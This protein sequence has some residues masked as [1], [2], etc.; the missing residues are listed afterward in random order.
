MNCES[1]QRNIDSFLLEKKRPLTQNESNH[2]A[3]CPSCREYYDSTFLLLKLANTLKENE[4]TQKNASSLTESIMLEINK[5]TESKP[6]KKQN[7]IFTSLNF[8]RLLAAASICLLMIFGIEQYRV[9]DK[10]EKSETANSSISNYP[11]NLTGTFEGLILLKLKF[12]NKNFEKI[13][14]ETGPGLQNNKEFLAA[15]SNFKN[16]NFSKK[17]LN[18]F[19]G[20]NFSEANANNLIEI[21][22]SKNSNNFI[23]N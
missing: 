23:K 18:D 9:L 1:V 15:T 17:E 11:Q 8:Q 19:L 7:T 14:K 5:E 4:P 21:I 6:V 12:Q 22:A 16:G 10:I 2:I 20:T 13:L 3:E